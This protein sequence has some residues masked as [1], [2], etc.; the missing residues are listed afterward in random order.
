M[1]R[2]LK[3][4]LMKKTLERRNELIEKK[5]NDILEIEIPNALNKGKS[6]VIVEFDENYESVIDLVAQKLLNETDLE[7]TTILPSIDYCSL[8]ETNKIKISWEDN[9]NS[10]IIK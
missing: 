9:T 8:K 7:V 5:F 4:E 3:E 2:N 10:I 6:F 1:K